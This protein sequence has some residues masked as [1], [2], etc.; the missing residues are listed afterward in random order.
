MNLAGEISLTSG[1]DVGRHISL[2][3][4]LVAV[5]VVVATRLRGAVSSRQLATESSSPPP[6]LVVIVSSRCSRCCWCLRS[7]CFIGAVCST[8]RFTVPVP[9]L[10]LILTGSVGCSL[11]SLGRIRRSVGIRVRNKSR[12]G[13]IKVLVR[14]RMGIRMSVRS[15]VPVVV[16][17]SVCLLICRVCVLRSGLAVSIAGLS[18]RGGGVTGGWCECVGGCGRC[19]R[20]C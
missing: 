13:R 18:C 17:V 1:G 8:R 9:W 11:C 5:A 19:G 6:S 16:R 3:M 15:S 14:V 4:R 20:S 10:P 2:L 7:S 12:G